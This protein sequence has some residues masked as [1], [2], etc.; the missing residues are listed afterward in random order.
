MYVGPVL[1]PQQTACTKWRNVIGFFILG[2]GNNYP[3]VIM[4]SAAFDI[5]HQLDG[6]GDTPSGDNG[7]NTSA[8]NDSCTSL[9]NWTTNTTSYKPREECQKQGT[10][11]SQVIAVMQVK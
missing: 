9:F 2:L 10:S 7:T 8:Y 4:L 1:P 5:I 11:V 6:G 3:Y